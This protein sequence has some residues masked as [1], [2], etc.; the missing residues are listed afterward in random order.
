[1]DWLITYSYA[2]AYGR[3]PEIA[4]DIIDCHPAKWLED[5][6]VNTEAQTVLLFA[7]EVGD[8]R[9]ALKRLIKNQKAVLTAKRF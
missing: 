5:A 3:I 7:I 9:E 2:L 4:N 1:M 6:M 8:G